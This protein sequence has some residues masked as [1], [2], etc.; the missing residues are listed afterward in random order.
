MELERK[1]IPFANAKATG[2]GSG[3][4]E[5]YASVFGQIDSYGDTIVPGAYANTI[6]DFQR[7]GF[8]AWGH[9]WSDLVGTPADI[10]EDEIGLYLRADFHTHAHAQ[11]ARQ[12]TSERLSRG[13]SMGLSIGYQPV[14][15]SYREA[16]GNRPPVR[17]LEEIKLYEVSLVAV[18]ADSFARVTGAKTT[19][20]FAD[21][22]DR[23]LA[24]LSA[25][26]ARATDLSELRAKEDRSLSDSHRQTLT[27]LRAQLDALLSE[28]KGEPDADP[29]RLFAEYQRTLARLNG[30]AV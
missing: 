19:Q 4:V 6:E 14:K 15:W 7:D 21:H 28:A 12:I 29:L 13:K 5:G 1:Q 3:S 26:V 17:V 25:F 23:V 2:E 27:Q 20:R 24:E 30:V 22:A 11:E 18:P 16:E 8:L 9:D 10:Y